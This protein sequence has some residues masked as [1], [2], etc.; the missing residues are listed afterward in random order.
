MRKSDPASTLAS[1]VLLLALSYAGPV[2]AAPGAPAQRKGAPAPAA[3]AP[4]GMQVLTSALNKWADL[5]EPADG[6]P[7]RTFATRLT[8]IKGEG[9]PKEV[10]DLTADLAYQAP[11]RLRLSA[12]VGKDAYAVGR[13]GQQ[14][15]V[16]MPAKQ[17]GL[18]GSPDVPRFKAFPD[19]G[20]KTQ[21]P[22]FKLPVAREQL[23][24]V[25]LLVHA[26]LGRPQEVEGQACHVLHLT[27][28][29][30]AAEL[31]GVSNPKDIKAELWVRASDSLPVRVAAADGKKL[32]VQIDFAAPRLSD[33]WAADKWNLAPA[34][35]D[36]IETVALAHL[37]RFLDVAPGLMNQ[38]IP[39]LGPVTGQRRLVVTSGK[40][41]LEEI[42]G[43]RVLFLKGSPE[44]MGR[45]HGELLKDEIRDVMGKILYGIGVGSS[46][47]KGNWFFGEIEG[48]QARLEP[49]IDD[50][51]LR[52]MDAMA[53]AVGLHRQEARLGNFFPELFHCSGFAIYGK[54]TKD[55]RMYHGR[56]LDYMKGVGLEQNA[57]VIVQQ[58][59]DGRHAWVNLSYA[60]FVGSITAMNEKG[61]GI[62]EMG[63]G[64][65]GHWDGKPM[66]QLMREVM[67]KADTLDEA[68]EI[69]R[70]GPRTCEYYYV[71]SDGRQ[72]K[73]V[74][75]ASTHETFETVAPGQSHPRLPHAIE[76]AVL[77]SAG[78]R[79][80]ELAR[81]VKANYGKFD[82]DSARELMTRPV[83]MTS[84]I[85]SVL[86]APD[87]LDFW[88][89]NADNKNVASHT[90]FTK[91]NLRELLKST[92]PAAPQAAAAGR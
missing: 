40:G 9:L 23:A 8:V 10:R 76:D 68:V 46:F 55:G 79:Y 56:V 1:L 36:K 6:Q 31:L 7:G 77:L 89:A 2:S 70:K 85:Q 15:W 81:R 51:Y 42:D 52:E 27:L 3:K 33:P 30:Q 75:I 50:V 11:D 19:E 54:A 38:K 73:A 17:F 43:T 59:D 28:L 84:N 57:V 65:Y 37:V 24:L 67:E 91:Y 69:M 72:M 83:C 39:T 29:P 32:D 45:Q 41:R 61:I 90:R 78:G 71:I 26:K 86:F 58:P 20:D 49:F 4:S 44:E 14:L 64:G 74:G 18:V 12:T 62:G 48:A 53:K 47:A 92:P 88:V 63:G 87:T 80:E 5:I 35:G 25:P 34:A 13:N 16:H 21:M 82:A 66:A 22:A 60:G